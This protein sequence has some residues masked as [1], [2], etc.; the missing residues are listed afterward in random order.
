M[1][2][3]LCHFKRRSNR[4]VEPGDLKKRNGNELNR[5]KP[6]KSRTKPKQMR[7]G[8]FDL[9]VMGGVWVEGKLQQSHASWRDGC[10]HASSAVVDLRDWC[11]GASKSF[12]IFVHVQS[13]GGHSRFFLFLF[14][15]AHS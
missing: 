4:P 13:G 12:D 11:V 2:H 3:R 10:S 6:R 7:R 14:E 5:T 15:A 8:A 9:G 1:G